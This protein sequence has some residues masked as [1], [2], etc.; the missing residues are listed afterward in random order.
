MS[1]F[2]MSGGMFECHEMVAM[3]RLP[4]NGCHGTVAMEWLPWN[5]CHGS[6]LNRHELHG[7]RTV[8]YAWNNGNE[9]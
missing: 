6:M 1:L 9:W 2:L 4:W 5:G 3:E 8:W 7:G